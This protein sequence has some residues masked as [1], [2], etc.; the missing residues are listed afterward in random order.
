MAGR[1]G[2]SVDSRQLALDV[3]QKAK[4][5]LTMYEN[6]L[7]VRVTNIGAASR[8]S[9]A[10]LNLL[11]DVNSFVTA[12]SWYEQASRQANSNQSSLDSVGRVVARM[13][14]NVEQSMQA[15]SES[16]QVRDSWAGIRS[17]LR[18]LRLDSQ[19]SSRF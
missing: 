18:Q 9:E 11:L 14:R 4:S 6:N 12:A 7:G 1:G 13:A 3:S 10:D 5:L 17:D 15:A 16:A 8:T 19:L 2:T